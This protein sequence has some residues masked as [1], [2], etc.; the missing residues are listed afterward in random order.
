MAPTQSSSP[1]RA[2][3]QSTLDHFVNGVSRILPW[4]GGAAGGIRSPPPPGS[5]LLD[6]MSPIS[7]GGSQK[8]TRSERRT[9]SMIAN[10]SIGME[11]TNVSDTRDRAPVAI[12]TDGNSVGPDGGDL[13]DQESTDSGPPAQRPRSEA[14]QLRDM[15]EHV[16]AASAN[17]GQSAEAETAPIPVLVTR[18]GDF[19]R[20]GEARSVETGLRVVEQTAARAVHFSPVINEVEAWDGAG[21]VEQDMYQDDGDLEQLRNDALET[22]VM[23]TPA[24]APPGPPG[25][26]G[27]E[28]LSMLRT[29]L[30]PIHSGV[31]E[32]QSTMA[33]MVTRVDEARAVAEGANAKAED[34]VI[35]SGLANEAAIRAESLMRDHLRQYDNRVVNVDGRMTSMERQIE[36]LAR[37]L[38]D[39]VRIL[40]EQQRQPA[41]AGDGGAA[42]V[43]PSQF[44]GIDAEKLQKMIKEH[45]D[46]ENEYWRRSILVSNIRLPG[47]HSGSHPQARTQ[48]R[49]VHLAF[50]LEECDTYFVTSRGDVRLTFSGTTEAAE[51]FGMAKRALAHHQVRGARVSILVPPSEV[52]KKLL[53]LRLGK[54]LKRAGECDN[55]EIVTRRGVVLLRTFSRSQGNMLHDIEEGA[56]VRADGDGG[57]GGGGTEMGGGTE[58]G[59]TGDAPEIC[60]VC[61]DPLSS[62]KTIKLRACGHKVHLYCGL[63]NFYRNGFECGLCRGLP[64]EQI[65]NQVT[66]PRCTPDVNYV[67]LIPAAC[68][69]LHHRWCQMEYMREEHMRELGEM[70]PADLRELEQQGATKCYQCSC[71]GFRPEFVDII[72]T[73]E[74][75]PVPGPGRVV[76]SESRSRDR[77]RDYRQPGPGLMASSARQEY[78]NQTERERERE[79]RGGGLGARPRDQPPPRP[80][81]TMCSCSPL[82]L[83]TSTRR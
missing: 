10:T 5:P 27:H 61:H 55:F 70:V 16:D 40:E 53:L 77:Q 29:E 76:I 46:R 68:G 20:S 28:F 15:E 1:R 42:A 45:T 32:V 44:A 31:N 34:A 19:S 13:S 56:L 60:Y 69:H 83:G 22:M 62:Q 64:S 23:S 48:L 33:G 63:V 6:G 21:D 17:I 80:I 79:S 82:R 3:R 18:S 54:D 51:M 74:R 8:R 2:S 35:Q 43:L 72:A 52:P 47:P 14:S 9:E 26:P 75:P 12:N 49:T 67:A 24:L 38:N 4:S 7:P 59:D 36:D 11:M 73:L 57:S 81:T 65:V 37:Q 58:G 30:A 41:P 39:R 71:S 78:A 25:P 50:L 66:C